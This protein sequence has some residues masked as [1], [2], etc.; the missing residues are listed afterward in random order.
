[1]AHI[2]FLKSLP[3]RIGNLLDITAARPGEGP[4]LRGYVVIDPKNTPLKVGE[5]LSEDRY[6]ASSSTST[7][8]TLRGKMGG[9]AILELLQRKIDIIQLAESSAP[10]CAPRPATP[11]GRSTPSA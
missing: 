8:T 7:A 5:L 10:T 11:S 4:L 1:V 2:W 6:R 9:D 3:S